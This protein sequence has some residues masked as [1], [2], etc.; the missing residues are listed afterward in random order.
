MRVEVDHRGQEVV[1]LVAVVAVLQPDVRQVRVTDEVRNRLAGTE[2][3][4]NPD[5]QRVDVGLLVAASTQ[6]VAKLARST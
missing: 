6:V 2:R 5:Q 4:A 3:L 1:D